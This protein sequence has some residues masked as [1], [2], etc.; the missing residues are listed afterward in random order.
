[1][2]SAIPHRNFESELVFSASK[3]SGPGGQNVNKV[4]SKVEL[5]FSVE[6]STILSD[7]EKQKIFKSLHKRIKSNGE[8]VIIS[9]SE[10]SQ[11]KNKEKT[12]ERFYSLLA[13]ALVSRKKRKLTKPTKASVE[14]R[15]QLKKIKG[16][17]KKLRGKID[18]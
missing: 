15:I 6:N 10:R 9:Q 2:N 12:I 16:E 8:L 11:L 14:K 13:K 1:M 7:I 3:S 4:N 5:R 17:R 18:N